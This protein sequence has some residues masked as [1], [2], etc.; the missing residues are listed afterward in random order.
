LAPEAKFIQDIS[1]VVRF[2]DSNDKLIEVEEIPSVGYDLQPAGYNRFDHL[3]NIE[4]KFID[5]YTVSF[6]VLR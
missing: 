2:Y 1:T 6:K 5:H 4:P 3:V